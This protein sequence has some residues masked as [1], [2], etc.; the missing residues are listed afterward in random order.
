[1]VLVSRCCRICV[2]L[3][4][5]DAVW[6]VVGVVVFHGVMVSW[7]FCLCVFLDDGFVLAVFA[8]GGHVAFA[9]LGFWVVGEFLVFV[10]EGEGLVAFV[11][12]A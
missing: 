11:A 4:F 10:L 12:V 2:V 5:G 8:G 3:S 1:M 9:V 6:V 7:F